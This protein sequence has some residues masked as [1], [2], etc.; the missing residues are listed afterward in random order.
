MLKRFRHSLK[1]TADRFYMG[2]FLSLGLAISFYH[3][4]VL[5]FEIM[6]VLGV[7]RYGQMWSPGD[8]ENYFHRWIIALWSLLLGF[9]LLLRYWFQK[10]EKTRFGKTFRRHRILNDHS[11]LIWEFSFLFLHIGFILSYWFLVAFRDLGNGF[12]ILFNN[13]WVLPFALV[14]I[15][16]RYW[17]NLLLH[18]RR[19]GFIALLLSTVIIAGLSFSLALWEIRD[20]DKTAQTL[21]KQGPYSLY[22]IQ[23]PKSS[24]YLKSESVLSMNEVFLFENPKPRFYTYWQGE[25]ELHE[26]YSIYTYH[27]WRSSETRLVV[28]RDLSMRT[29]I[30]FHQKVMVDINTCPFFYAVQASD[31][32]GSFQ[33][34]VHCNFPIWIWNYNHFDFDGIESPFRKVIRIEPLDSNHILL[35]GEPVDLNLLPM[36]LMDVIQERTSF[37]F[38]FKNWD[39]QHFQDYFKVLIEIRSSLELLSIKSPKHQ[40]YQLWLWF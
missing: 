18:F 34:S 35:N 30:A 6:K 36:L 24:F 13:R 15:Y 31:E 17:S 20:F 7:D 21:S 25:H 3:F 40:K 8:H 11:L 28:D 10:P 4:I 37:G 23:I 38:H 22:D 16:F 5:L 9:D 2:L 19:K 26:F 32:L 33:P 1:L 14:I 27:H 12:E 39:Q 29:L